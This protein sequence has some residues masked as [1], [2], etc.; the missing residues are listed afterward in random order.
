MYLKTSINLHF[1]KTIV[2]E[3]LLPLQLANASLKNTSCILYD[4]KYSLQ[5]LNLRMLVSALQHL[6]MQI[7]RNHLSI[8]IKV[9]T[10]T[11]KV[12]SLIRVERNI[13]IF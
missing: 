6:E 2:L 7:N 10:T 5:S 3:I 12:Q 8:T 9:S 13:F 1:L 4:C 11:P